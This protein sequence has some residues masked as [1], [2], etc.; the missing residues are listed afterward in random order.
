MGFVERLVY[1]YFI[2]TKKTSDYLCAQFI[3]GESAIL[4]GQEK[5][6]FPESSARFQSGF[7]NNSGFAGLESSL[8][9]ILRLV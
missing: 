1:R 2:V 3:G 6:S 7:R 8:R 9:Y 5:I 4:T